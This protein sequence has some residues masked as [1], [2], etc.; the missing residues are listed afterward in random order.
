MRQQSEI[1]VQNLQ[2]KYLNLHIVS[3]KMHSLSLLIKVFIFILTPLSEKIFFLA[4]I[5]VEKFKC[6]TRSKQL[7][8]QGHIETLK[9]Y[10]TFCSGKKSKNLK[11]L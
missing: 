2:I 9:K 10:S 11:F 5:S 4:L 8:E 6:L 7:P 3:V 1:Q